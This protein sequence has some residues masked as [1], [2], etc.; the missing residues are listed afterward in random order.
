MT[1]KVQRAVNLQLAINAREDELEALCAELTDEEHAEVEE[2]LW[3]AVMTPE[4]REQAEKLLAYLNL[5]HEHD[6][7]PQ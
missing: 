4:T 3:Q 6:N 5:K 1:E 2:L 7:R